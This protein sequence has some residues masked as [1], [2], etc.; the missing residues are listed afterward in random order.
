[1][2]THMQEQK[3]QGP[4][5]PVRH[6]FLIVPF[7]HYHSIFAILHNDTSILIK[8]VTS[9]KHGSQKAVGIQYFLFTQVKA[10]T[11]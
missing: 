5:T 6:F 2:G 3:S 1:M 8:A 11:P 9:D 7:D 4:D 10:E